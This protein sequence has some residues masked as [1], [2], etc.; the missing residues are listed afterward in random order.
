MKVLIVAPHFH[1]RVGGVETYTLNIATRLVA[2]G[3]QVAIVTTGGVAEAESRERQTVA[4]MPVYRLP[5]ALT[6][7]N[8]PVGFRWRNKLA[9]ILDDE[10]PDVINAHTPV[11][12][13]ADM[14]QRASGSIPFVLTYHNDLAKD[15]LL[16]NVAVTMLQHT[17]ID[18]TLCRASRII[19]TSDYYV[20][21]SRYLRGYESKIS[22]VPPGVDLTTFN[23]GI[24]VSADLA[25]R[26]AGHRV[27][28]FVGSLNKSQRYKGLDVLISAF[29][30]VQA[31]S[32]DLR[33]VVA[34][35]GDGLDMYRK[36]AAA[37]G[38]AD[39]VDF[40]GYVGHDELPQYYKLAR[41]FAMP[42]TSR[43]EGFGTVYV[44]AGAVGIPVIG[45]RIGGVPSAVRNDETGLLVSPR[46]APG[47]ASALRRVLGD[48]AL[49][50]RL[51]DAAAT[52]A[53]A[54]FDWYFLARRT[55]EVLGATCGQKVVAGEY[56]RQ[57]GSVP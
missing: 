42:S 15:A 7:S 3:W 49:A 43:T 33:L 31:E 29:S 5:T 10:R 38:V 22:V 50:K 57:T 24:R 48:D 25:R 12:Y 8:T 44:E 47:L 4:G 39:H 45:S 34:G 19:A 17:L 26:Y 11:P 46:D 55:S 30:R 54:E 52:R 13:L 51:G 28:L 37:A 20:R 32:P 23:P 9:R 14:A 40:A 2:L 6:V 35:A 41:V 56:A 21:E 27:V 36:S 18:R 16:A 53:R 1:P